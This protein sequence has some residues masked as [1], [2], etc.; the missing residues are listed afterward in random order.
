MCEYYMHLGTLKG[1][2][3]ISIVIKAKNMHSCT[4]K[5]RKLV[6]KHIRFANTQ[7]LGITEIKGDSIRFIP[8][9]ENER[10][11]TND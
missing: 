11:A 6:N 4:K 1:G 5:Y 3:C 10:S 2:H 8:P 7:F 9:T